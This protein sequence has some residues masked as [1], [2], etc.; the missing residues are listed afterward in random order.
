MADQKYQVFVLLMLDVCMPVVSGM[1]LCGRLC[2]ER[3]LSIVCH[4][5]HSPR[6]PDDIV[7][8]LRVGA[9][10]YIVKSFKFVELVA[11]IELFLRC[12]QGLA[13]VRCTVLLTFGSTLHCTVL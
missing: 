10:N 7:K 13:I 2:A 9:D 8:R 1:E 5:D 6:Y 11:C 12:T 3:G 4:Y